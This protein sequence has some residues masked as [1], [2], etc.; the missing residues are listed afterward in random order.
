MIQQRAKTDSPNLPKL[1]IGS[2]IDTMEQAYSHHHI[3]QAHHS[4]IV[5]GTIVG[6]C[7]VTLLAALALITAS[8]RVILH[9]LSL[10]SK[11]SVKEDASHTTKLG[12]AGQQASSGISSNLRLP[13]AT[14]A[15]AKDFNR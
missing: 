13:G 14:A 11:L 8:P 2:R 7:A 12:A 1:G 3:Q 5:I 4:G 9:P 10:S 6:S 15:G